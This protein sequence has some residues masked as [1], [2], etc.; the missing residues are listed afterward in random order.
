MNKF[1]RIFDTV[2]HGQILVQ[3]LKSKDEGA[4]YIEWTISTDDYGT[5]GIEVLYSNTE[6]G[7][8][9]AKSAFE[10]FDTE[11]AYRVADVILSLSDETTSDEQSEGNEE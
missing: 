4:P 5:D 6:D 11:M 1:C 3:L 10:Q 7:W 8:F 2:K 9:Q